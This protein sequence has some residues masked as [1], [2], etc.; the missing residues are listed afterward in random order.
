MRCM[1]FSFL[2]L[3]QHLPKMGKTPKATRNYSYHLGESFLNL[4]F[5]DHLPLEHESKLGLS[6]SLWIPPP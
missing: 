2:L 4:C 6:E 1:H 5:M 3:T